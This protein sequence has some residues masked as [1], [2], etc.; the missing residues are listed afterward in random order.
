MNRLSTALTRRCLALPAFVVALSVGSIAHADSFVLFNFSNSGYA[1]WS[2]CGSGCVYPEFVNS[3]ATSSDLDKTWAFTAQWWPTLDPTRFTG[4]WA[5]HD[6]LDSDD[7]AG[8]FSGSMLWP[9]S[10]Y[11]I[12]SIDYT[13]GD[14][15][16]AQNTGI[17]RG[18]T[19]A[20][21][22]ALVSHPDGGFSETGRFFFQPAIPVPEPATWT[23]LG[24]GLLGIGA[25]ARRRRV[26]AR[27]R[28]ILQGSLRAARSFARCG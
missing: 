4:I 11:A 21:S 13:I 1:V 8:S 3:M 14:T 19:G 24:A 15:V 27:V 10:G 18:A 7:L 9:S 23:T 2:A 25:V 26:R 5:L 16:S 17:F 20:G 22:T 6:V 28:P 12:A